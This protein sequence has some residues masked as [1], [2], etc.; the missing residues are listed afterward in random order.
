MSGPASPIGVEAVRVA[1]LDADGSPDFDNPTGGFMMC[2]GVSTF[3]FD[4]EVEAG[5]D[6]FEKDASG[7]ACVVRKRQDLVKRVTFT[8]TMCKDDYR[9]SEILLGSGAEAIT[10]GSDVVGIAY[11]SAQ[12]C[13]NPDVFNGVSIEL[14]SRQWDCDVPLANAP[15]RRYV[16]PRA[17]LTPQGYTL[18]DG[19]SNPTYGG[20]SVPNDLWGDGPFGDADILNSTTGY[21]LAMIDNDVVPDC[22]TP[23]GYINVPGSAS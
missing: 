5:A 22:P 9:L 4:F 1:R 19:V 16:L 20:F 12:G 7:A 8:L 15:F 11:Q 18:Q 21:P 23:I 17:Y 3:Q 14:W 2:G 6:I 10:D 13:G